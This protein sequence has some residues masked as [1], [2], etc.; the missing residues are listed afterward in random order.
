ML[1]D[2]SWIKKKNKEEIKRLLET[3]NETSCLNLWDKAQAENSVIQAY[4][5]KKEKENQ[6]P[7]HTPREPETKESRKN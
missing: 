7:K 5:R 6:Q 2:S 3:D 4:V 1:L